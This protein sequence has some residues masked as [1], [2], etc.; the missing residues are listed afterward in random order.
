M[1]AIRSYYDL[2][3]TDHRQ[4]VSKRAETYDGRGTDRS[5]HAFLAEL[6]TTVDIADM[7]FDSRQRNNFV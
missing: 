5:D 6:F 1:Y 2:R 3:H 7:H 4:M